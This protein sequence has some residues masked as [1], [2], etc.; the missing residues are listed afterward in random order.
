MMTPTF[1]EMWDLPLPPPPPH[2]HE[3]PP[4]IPAESASDRSLQLFA[5]KA[6]LAKTNK[7]FLVFIKA[8]AIAP[9][10]TTELFSAPAIFFSF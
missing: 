2:S 1:R 9:T 7:R 8:L 5:L 10:Y 3:I 4:T 6:G